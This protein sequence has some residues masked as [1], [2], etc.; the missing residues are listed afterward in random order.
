M[1]FRTRIFCYLTL[2]ILVLVGLLVQE[3]NGIGK[4]STEKRRQRSVVKVTSSE[5]RKVTRKLKK[6]LTVLQTMSSKMSTK[7]TTESIEQKAVLKAFFGPNMTKEAVKQWQK[8]YVTGIF[9]KGKKNWRCFY[10]N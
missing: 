8:E 5:S 6:S 10:K 9:L 1:R 4:N 7:S 2:G 3:Q